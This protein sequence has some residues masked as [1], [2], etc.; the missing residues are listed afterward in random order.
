MYYL[1]CPPRLQ[2]PL[3]KPRHAFV[4]RQLRTACEN[5]CPQQ[6]EIS[7][8]GGCDECW[9]QQKLT[10]PSP[11]AHLYGHLCRGGPVVS[12]EHPRRPSPP[13]SVHQPLGDLESTSGQRSILHTD[14]ARV[15]EKKG[16]NKYRIYF[17]APSLPNS[18]SS[19]Y[20][21]SHTTRV[22]AE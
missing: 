5:V 10:L 9:A 7:I 1:V 19:V 17:L 3:R 4:A 21:R 20:I 16:K 11:E 12:V 15:G 13:R 22:S 14:E 6:K 8:L 2:A 18:N